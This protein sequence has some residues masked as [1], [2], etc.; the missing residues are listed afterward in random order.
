MITVLIGTYIIYLAHHHSHITSR[1][2]VENM[3]IIININNSIN[4]VS[5]IIRRSNNLHREFLEN[6]TGNWLSSEPDGTFTFP[7]RVQQLL[8]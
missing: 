8:Y 4:M 5:I 2:I 7:V 6:R 1:N 3:N